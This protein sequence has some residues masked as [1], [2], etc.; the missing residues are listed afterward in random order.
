MSPTLASGG[1]EFRRQGLG[2][3]DGERGHRAGQRDVEP[4]QAA[5][6][7]TND[8]GRLD[9]HDVVE[10][11]P[12]H[13]RDGDQL[14]AAVDA[15]L[16]PA[17]LDPGSGQR[18]SDDTEIRRGGDDADRALLREPLRTVLA[19][20]AG[21]DE[22]ARSRNECAACRIDS[23]ASTPAASHGSN[24]L[25]RSSTSCG[26][27]SRGSAPPARASGLPRCRN[28]S[29]QLATASGDVACAMS[30]HRRG[31]GLAAP[32]QRPA[33]HRRR[34]PAPRRR[35]DA[36]RMVAARRERRPR[37]PGGVRA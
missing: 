12:L 15:V 9:H 31:A 27:G 1:G 6:L 18:A 30:Q 19:T 21:T 14:D 34:G 13:S 4:V 33:L 2:I 35:P 29:G 37:R 16:D 10:L 25:A 8:R 11:Q 7:G 36:R 24:R 23:A 26:T 32:A 20:A 22:V 3:H 28:V 17:G 5:V